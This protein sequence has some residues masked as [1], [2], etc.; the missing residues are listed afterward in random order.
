MPCYRH[1]WQ[2]HETIHVYDEYIVPGG[3]Y[4]L[5]AIYLGCPTDE[6][7]R[8]TAPAMQ[9]T[10]VWGDVAGPFVDGAWT[11]PDGRVDVIVD[12][13]AILDKYRNLGG[14]PPKT[15]ADLAGV[16]PNAALPDL[17]IAVLDAVYGIYAFQGDEFPF[18]PAG[19]PCP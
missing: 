8:Y 7:A 15:W 19:D 1:D 14:A 13:V 10:S 16:P 5:Q 4:E 9:P 2:I 6:E 17:K 3:V 12:V 18:E 11:A